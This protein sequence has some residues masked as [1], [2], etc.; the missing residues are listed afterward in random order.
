MD[1]V[2]P[3]N[4][5]PPEEQWREESVPEQIRWEDAEFEPTIVRGR[6]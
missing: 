2:E 6:E 1:I 3:R 5:G 4:P